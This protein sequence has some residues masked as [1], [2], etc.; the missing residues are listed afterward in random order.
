M[1][2]LCKYCNNLINYTH[3]REFS[4]H[5]A[6]CLSN[7]RVRNKYKK[8]AETIKKK[9]WG[10]Y[11]IKC[12]NCSKEFK[13]YLTHSNFLKNKYRKTC[14]SQ[15]AHHR[16]VS[17]EQKERTSKKLRKNNIRVCENCGK[18]DINFDFIRKRY[19]NKYCQ[20]E[21]VLKKKQKEREICLLNK[22]I[23]EKYYF[24]CKFKFNVYKYPDEFDLELPTNY[25][26]YHHKNNKN[27]I[28]RDHMISVNYGFTNNIDPY[29][30]SHPANCKLIHHKYNQIKGTKCSLSIEELKIR[31]ENWNKTYSPLR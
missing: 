7:P 6:S 21:V 13:L 9:R 31:I 25:G 24:N 2:Q 20:N 16:K 22:S 8:A 5:C 4:C 15:C 1:Q 29:I 17:N 10:T 26:W 3:W 11:I 18:K 28:D 12:H 14:S 19:C 23:K 27:G 30:I